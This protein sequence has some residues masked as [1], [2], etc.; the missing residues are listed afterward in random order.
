M[1]FGSREDIPGL[2]ICHSSF[3]REDAQV[4]E[5]G[6]ATAEGERASG[7]SY[8]AGGESAVVDFPYRRAVDK[9]LEIVATRNDEQGVFAAYA[10]NDVASRCLDQKGG[11]I[12]G[13]VAQIEFALVRDFKIVEFILG[14]IGAKKQSCI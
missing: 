13:E 11:F 6:V 8:L 7:H 9:E 12:V 4:G 1:S 3:H 10:L 14:R 2:H 5:V